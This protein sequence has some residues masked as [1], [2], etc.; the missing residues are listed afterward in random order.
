MHLNLNSPGWKASF[1]QRGIAPV[2]VS[3]HRIYLD[4]CRGDHQRC[5]LPVTKSFIFWIF[6][7][8]NVEAKTE[9]NF[10]QLTASSN[11]FPVLFLLE[12]T[13]VGVGDGDGEG[14]G[15]AEGDGGSGWA[16][17]TG[18]GGGRGAFSSCSISFSSFMRPGGSTLY[19]DHGNKE[20]RH[21]TVRIKKMTSTNQMKEM[22]MFCY[23]QKFQSRTIPWC[24]SS[25]L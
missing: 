2:S 17:D 13:L 1:L 11:S 10:C 19:L 25:Q 21:V 5:V 14:V 16:G 9:V 12:V 8:L 23:K 15:D 20:E 18:D 4:I 6:Q 7:A 24:Y 3:Q 22:K